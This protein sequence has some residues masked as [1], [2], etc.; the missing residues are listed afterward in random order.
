[1]TYKHTCIRST[2]PLLVL[3]KRG[4]EKRNGKTDF[5]KHVI[6][7]LK[8]TNNPRFYFLFK[9]NKISNILFYIHDRTKCFHMYMYVVSFIQ[10]ALWLSV[11]LA[12]GRLLSFESRPRQTQVVQTGSDSSTAKC[13]ATDF[14]IT[15]PRR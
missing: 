1:M 4:I 10:C 3:L 14:N 7:Y 11:R 8:H 13:L 5:V 6:I 9:R 12:C 2:L 15:G